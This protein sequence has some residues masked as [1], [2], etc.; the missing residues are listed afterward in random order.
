VGVRDLLSAAARQAVLPRETDH[1]PWPLPDE[2]WRLAETL[3]DALFAHWRVP[4]DVVRAQLPAGLEVDTFADSAWL[5]VVALCV[6]AL[7]V[8]GA[9]P[10]P[11]LS[12]F[13]QLNVRTYVTDGSRP[14]I[15]FFSLDVPNR[16]AVE[17]GRRLYRLPFAQARITRVEEGGWLDCESARIG[18]G[19]LR[20]FSARF[21]PSGP[22]ARAEAG[23][24]EWFL[25]ERFCLY[26][27]D[28]GRLARVEIHHLPW[29]LR[30][31][32]GQVA[33]NTMAP[34]G[35][36]LDEAPSLMHFAAR[37][38]VLIWPL[39]SLSEVPPKS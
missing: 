27:V 36:D 11:G 39:E 1:R 34:P 24:L 16:A 14:G 12:G 20:V 26:A 29:P 10:V 32:E 6:S 28:R 8:R 4:R 15:W 23:T 33:L 22:E 25:C 3:E 13:P 2:P 9:L 19:D 35:V 7:R 5:S 30:P 37:Q 31:A 38:D 18:K 21:R 17:A